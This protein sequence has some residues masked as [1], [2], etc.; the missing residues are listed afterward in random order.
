M[1]RIR[2]HKIMNSPDGG[3]VSLLN[4]ARFYLSPLATII[5]KHALTAIC[6]SCLNITALM[7]SIS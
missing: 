6:N 4:I 5:Y 1:A 7:N 2:L 3:N